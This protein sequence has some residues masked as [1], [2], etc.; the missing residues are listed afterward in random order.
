[1][2]CAHEQ[3]GDVHDSC[4]TSD[5]VVGELVCGVL[6]VAPSVRRAECAPYCKKRQHKTAEKY[7]RRESYGDEIGSAKDT[8]NTGM[9]SY[10]NNT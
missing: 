6:A 7:H 2:I 5:L 3:H 4:S 8:R 9:H 1:M 10:N